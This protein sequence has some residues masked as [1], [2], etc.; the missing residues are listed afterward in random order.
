MNDKVDTVGILLAGGL[1]RRMGGGDKFFREVGRR[2]ILDWVI[3]RSKP[4]VGEL[5]LNANGDLTRFKNF[6]LTIVPDVIT[7]FAGP[8][9]G[10]LSGLEWA[11]HNSPSINWVVSFAT[12]APFIPR[13]MVEMFKTGVA[14]ENIDIVCA[15]SGGRKHPVFALWP[16]KIAK[17][18]RHAITNENIRKIDRFTANYRIR[19]IEFSIDPVDPFFNIN[20]I[21]NLSEAEL[22][23]RKI[24]RLGDV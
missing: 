15:S 18:L 1:G 16:V 12:D 24:N 9:A 14:T 3:E 19:E 6:G 21:A 13:N 7:G 23:C 17:D 2:K 10:I 11:L 4:Q 5:I 22:L 8:L 20:D